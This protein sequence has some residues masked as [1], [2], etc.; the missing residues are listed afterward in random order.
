[1]QFRVRDFIFGQDLTELARITDICLDE[2]DSR[3]IDAVKNS[4]A[5]LVTDAATADNELGVGMINKPFRGFG[6]DASITAGNQYDLLIQWLARFS[7][8]KNVLLREV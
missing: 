2:I 7:W 6:A 3:E 1:M 5:T 8:S 4:L